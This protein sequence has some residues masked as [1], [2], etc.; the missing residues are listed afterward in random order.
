MDPAKTA[1]STSDESAAVGVGLDM[2]GN[3]FLYWI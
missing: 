3:R 1:K 2:A